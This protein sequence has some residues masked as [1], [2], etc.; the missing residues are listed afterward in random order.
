MVFI[1]LNLPLSRKLNGYATG[2]GSN[3]PGK[4]GYNRS[5]AW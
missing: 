3:S 1:P 5:P 4:S 2:N